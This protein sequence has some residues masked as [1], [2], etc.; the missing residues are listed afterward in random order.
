MKKQ[1]KIQL[2]DIVPIFI[3]AGIFIIFT[4]ASNGATLSS[5]NLKLLC[6]NVVPVIIGS[7]GCIFVIALGGTDISIGASAALC[8]SI[9]AVI[10]AQTAGWVAIPVTIILSTAL[11]ALIGFIVTKFHVGSFMC[12]LAILIAGRGLLNFMLQ[13]S[14]IAAP[15][16]I[17]FVTTFAFTIILLIALIVIVWFVFEYTKFGFYCKCIGENERTVHSVG[18]NVKKIRIICFM[19][20]GL[21]AGIIGLVQICRVGGSTST[22]CNMLEMKVQMA[23]FL[24]GILTTGGFS[25]KIYKLIIGSFTIVVIENGMIILGVSSALSEAIEGIILVAILITT[26]Y[27]SKVAVNKDLKMAALADKESVAES[28]AH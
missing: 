12:T 24:G 11:G 5:Y 21:M 22:L 19:I 20:S 27:C 9:A 7:L 25:A 4:V 15:K 23:I 28:A 16:G 1:S 2:L 3:L 14:S 6:T 17:S 8:S 13:Q 26:V 10:S 18:I